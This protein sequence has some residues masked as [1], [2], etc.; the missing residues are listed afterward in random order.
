MNQ[1]PTNQGGGRNA[2]PM[3]Q[4]GNNVHPTRHRRMKKKEKKAHR[5]IKSSM[6]NPEK[7]RQKGYLRQMPI[8]IEEAEDDF[9][10]SW[11]QKLPL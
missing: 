10:N 8:L 2:Q 6:R 3:G 5:Q 4:Q 1:Q 11:F 7:T 9:C